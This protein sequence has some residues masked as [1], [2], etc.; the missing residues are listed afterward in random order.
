MPTEDQLRQGYLLAKKNGNEVKAQRYV[1]LI[2]EGQF[3]K[4]KPAPPPPADS[5][6]T[7]IDGVGEAWDRRKEE[8]IESREDY[9][10]GEIGFGEG[11]VQTAGQYAGFAGDV[12]GEGIVHT[13]QT[14]GDGL[15]YAFPE[16]YE[17]AAD[18]IKSVTNWVMQSEAGQAASEAFGK[19]YTSYQ[20][21]LL[22]KVE[23][24]KPTGCQ[25]I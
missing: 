7:F 20:I 23:E 9:A 15:E 18:S 21:Y 17:G 10:T 25:N 12:I 5:D 24:G 2:K 3:D 1:T 13:F 8:I 22:S 19:G 16:E 6:P 4:V 14:I 11:A